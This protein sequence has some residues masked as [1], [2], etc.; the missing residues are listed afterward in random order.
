MKTRDLNQSA[1]LLAKGQTML[2]SYPDGLSRFWFVFKD[3]PGLESLSKEY[4]MNRGSVV[5]QSF[6]IAQKTLKNLVRNYKPSNIK[7]EERESI[8]KGMRN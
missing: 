6:V 7:N 4:Y 2:N 8:S 1:Y 5:P 3:D